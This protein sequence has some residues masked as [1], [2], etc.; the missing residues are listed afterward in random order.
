MLK[1]VQHVSEFFFNSLE[2]RL[3]IF[4]TKHCYSNVIICA[5]PEFQS[6]LTTNEM[7]QNTDNL[8]SY[9]SCS[10]TSYIQYYYSCFQTAPEK[11]FPKC[12]MDSS[13]EKSIL[14]I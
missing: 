6:L 4:L 5:K 9:S 1:T 12:Y 14:K 10:N 13:A 11:T 8:C 3:F 7:R 2:T